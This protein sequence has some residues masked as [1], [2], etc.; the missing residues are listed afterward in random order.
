MS[1]ILERA[2]LHNR[3]AWDSFRRQRD[4]GL[5][6]KHVDIAAEI[7]AG[8]SALSPQQR[9][10]AGDVAGKHL[11]DLGCGDGYELLEWARLGADVVG[12]DNS[13]QQIATAQRAAAR[14]D[15]SCQ[16][17]VADLL[18]LPA[19][20]LQGEF[21]IV[22]SAWVTAWIGDLDRWF[23]SVY[24]ALKPGGILL[25][26]GGHPFSSFIQDI[27]SAEK[28]RTSY[29]E[30]GP[31]IEESM[32]PDEWNPAGD[33]LTTIQWSPTLGQI[34]TAVAQ[35]GLVISHLIEMG[36]ATEKFGL[37]GYPLE[38]ILRAVKQ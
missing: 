22:F 8:K 12:V 16:L 17:I 34:V 32:Q 25:L 6:D 2:A 13:P 27:Q 19:E 28:L 20:L 11:L 3:Q 5:V 10:L 38:F 36:D 23:H 37:A 35:S 21:D 1:D 7:L 24:L 30:E 4:E 14:L 18:Q 15:I 26:S 31:F 9:S 33:R 29:F